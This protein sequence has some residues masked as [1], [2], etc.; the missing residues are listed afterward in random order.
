MQTARVAVSNG[1]RTMLL[2]FA[3]QFVFLTI[4]FFLERMRLHASV[5]LSVIYSF[6]SAR[7]FQQ[8]NPF[9]DSRNDGNALA[10][11]RCF[12]LKSDFMDF[13][14]VF[15]WESTRI[16]D[17][18]TPTKTT[19]RHIYDEKYICRFKTITPVSFIF[20]RKGT[21][22][23]RLVYISPGTLPKSTGSIRLSFPPS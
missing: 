17:E 8:K 4:L 22:N 9:T 6:L 13:R 1:K 14:F 19:C 20:I 23:P 2:I 10:S 12:L 3:K 16:R 15:V 7:M 11:I 18:I 21:K 5:G